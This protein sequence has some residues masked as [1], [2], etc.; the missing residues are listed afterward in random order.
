MEP[1]VKDVMTTRVVSVTRDASFRTMAA[2]LRE[3]RVSA[4][5]VLDDDEKVIGLVSEADMLVKEALDS[6]PE[7]MPGMIGGLLRRREHEKAR[8]ITAGDLM[9]SPAVTITP[10]DTI[11]RAARLMYVLRV[12]RLPVV[13]AGGCLVGIV[14]RADLLSVFDRGDEEICAEIV[15]DVVLREFLI[16]PAL[17]TVTVADGVVTIKGAPE[18][19]DA[20]HNLVTRIRHVRGV[21]A[22]RDELA[23]PPSE[24]LPAGLYT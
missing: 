10:D 12:K 4:F 19:A 18:T 23:Y 1:T 22:V 7:G 11:E 3:H 5:P 9:T 6:E 13:D 14:S 15:E 2:A 16:D 8:G 17:F 20:G 21:V 24:R